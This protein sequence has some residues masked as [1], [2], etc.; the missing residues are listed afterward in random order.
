M[1]G[2]GFI[3]LEAVEALLKLGLE[4]HLVEKLPSAGHRLA[5]SHGN[6][7]HTCC[8]REERCETSPCSTGGSCCHG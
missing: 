8:G 5:A 4:V 2:A 7:G 1:V 3:G 6:G